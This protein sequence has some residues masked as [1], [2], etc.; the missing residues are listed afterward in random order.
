MSAPT[1]AEFRALYP[2]FTSAVD[3]LVQAHLDRAVR[4]SEVT[5][6]GEKYQDLVMLKAASSLALTPQGQGMR[7]DNKT[8]A[9]IYDEPLR[10]MERQIALRVGGRVL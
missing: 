3:A 6:A 2:A 7:L 8:S 4:D 1:L 5:Y 10:R 9:T